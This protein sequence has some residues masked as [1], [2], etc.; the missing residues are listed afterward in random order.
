MTSELQLT[1]EDSGFNW[2]PLR[3]H[4]P[5]I[6]H[7]IQKALGAFMSSLSVK[8]RTKC[9]EAHECIQ[10]FGVNESLDSAKNQRLQKEGHA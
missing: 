7:V 8:G 10:K 5:C 4:I 1:L 2:P 6:V 3:N 9:W